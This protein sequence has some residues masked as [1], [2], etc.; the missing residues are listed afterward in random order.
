MSFKTILAS[1]NTVTP[2]PTTGAPNNYTPPGRGDVMSGNLITS[3]AIRPSDHMTHP[4]VFTA[5]T[6][7]EGTASNP[8]NDAIS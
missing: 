1:A 4:G 5:G 2:N 3:R 8:T 7:P 6:S